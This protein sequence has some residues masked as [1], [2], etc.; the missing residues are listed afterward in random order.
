MRP[1]ITI[2]LSCVALPLFAQYTVETYGT[3]QGLSNRQVNCIYQDS[4]GFIWIGT[5]FGLNFFDGTQFTHY[6]HIPS[7]T[8]GLPYRTVL[9]IAE[10]KQGRLWL[11]TQSGVSCFDLLSKRFIN[12]SPSSTGKKKFNGSH[13]HVFLSADGM[14][15]IGTNK[16]IYSLNPSTDEFVFYPLQ[17]TP[18]NRFTNPFVTGFLEDAEGTLWAGTS[19][20]VYGKRKSDTTF[21]LF[22]RFNEKGEPY[23]CTRLIADKAGTIYCGTWNG[24]IL[25]KSRDQRFFK[26]LP[27]RDQLLG[28]RQ[29]FDILLESDGAAWIATEKGLIRANGLSENNPAARKDKRELLAG[30]FITVLKKDH[31]GKLWA[32]S[33]KGLTAIRDQLSFVQPFSF[34]SIN[35]W[36]PLCLLPE[37]NQTLVLNGLSLMR[38]DEKTK[39]FSLQAS[40]NNFP[41]QII[42]DKDRYWL[43]E[44]PGLF[45]LDKSL[46]KKDLFTFTDQSGSHLFFNY[47]LRDVEGSIWLGTS[48]RKGICIFDPHAKKWQHLLY[49]DTAKINLAGRSIHQIIEDDEGDVWIAARPLV[50]FHRATK[51]FEA[52]PITSPGRNTDEINNIRCLYADKRT[53]WIGTDCGLYFFNKDSNRIHEVSMPAMISPLVDAITMDRQGNLWMIA[54]NGLVLYD[55]ASGQF[56]LFNEMNGFPAGISEITRMPDGRMLIGYEGNIAFINPDLLKVRE[57]VAAP[58]WVEIMIDNHPLQ[59][60]WKAHPIRLKH[61]QNIGFSFLSPNYNGSARHQY[62]YKL[63][64]MDKDWNYIGNN[65]SQRFSNLPAGSYTFAVKAMNADGNWSNVTSFAFLVNPPFWKTWWFL[66]LLLVIV[67]LALYAAY[68][69]KLGQALKLERLRMRIATDLHDDIGATLSSISMYSEAVKK[70]VKEKMPQLQPVLDKM[71]D[72]SRRMVSSMSDIVWAV[73]PENDQG[74]KLLERIE[75]YARDACSVTGTKLHFTCVDELKLFSFPLEYRKNIYLVFK[76]SLNNAL[77]YADAR[78]IWIVMDKKASHFHLTI[79]DNGKGFDA[80][81]E[82]KGNG[83]KNLRARAKEINATLT[84]A[85]APHKGTVIGL[86]CKIS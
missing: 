13:C 7:D 82:F 56:K 41:G 49:G 48:Q 20:G 69:Y 65:T 25:Y 15:W 2:F 1:W 76:E 12:Y 38:F 42:K 77:K 68:R 23:E 70:Q 80:G 22:T 50:R 62:A 60:D 46:R 6:Y 63:E 14:V 9:S 66:I 33:T 11:G 24:G 19:Y 4:R 44:R 31:T 43:T 73:N 55:R 78:D 84:I 71:G 28:E 57:N 45:S 79:K 18:A 30:S 27:G 85:S 37:S 67:S 8:N 32:G 17:L 74:I 29:V 86:D 16:G 26:P 53:I 40:L 21:H 47:M 58:Q 35:D 5:N 52:V 10:D 81:G 34:A 51:Q 59:V 39:Q 36:N 75:S 83:L 61:N 54:S 72:N 64:S 3:R